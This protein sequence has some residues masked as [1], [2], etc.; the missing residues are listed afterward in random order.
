MKKILAGLLLIV[1]ASPSQAANSLTREQAAR[2]YSNFGL[3]GSVMSQAAIRKYGITGIFWRGSDKSGGYAEGTNL[4]NNP[5]DNFN[6]GKGW[7]EMTYISKYDKY[8]R[9]I[10][11]A[12]DHDRSITHYL[13][14]EADF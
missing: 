6:L 8:N 14:D 7:V 5:K 13:P 4:L 1:I 9:S 12:E 2:A 10:F 3:K 11:I